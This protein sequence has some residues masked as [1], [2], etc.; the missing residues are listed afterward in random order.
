MIKN[1]D[2]MIFLA[3][4]ALFQEKGEEEEELKQKKERKQ[5]T[6]SSRSTSF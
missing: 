4:L 3:H 2:L 1:S 6:K 5:K